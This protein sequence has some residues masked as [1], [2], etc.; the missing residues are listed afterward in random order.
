MPLMTWTK[1]H[2]VGIQVLDDDHKKLFDMV[3]QLHDGILEGRRHEVMGKVLEQ[4]VL[5]T[6]MHFKREETFMESTSF[7]GLA[8]HKKQHEDLVQKAAEL[9]ARYQQGASAMLSLETMRFLKDW[10]S[11]H[12]QGSDKKYGPHLNSKGI[13]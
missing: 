7:P 9:L 12:I 5:Y 2:S 11:V 3:N 4:L 6:Q 8:E 10:L 1:E 13:R